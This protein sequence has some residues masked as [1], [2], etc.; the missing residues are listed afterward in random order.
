MS[1]S[2]T[3]LN[4]SQSFRLISF[5]VYIFRRPSTNYCWALIPTGQHLTAFITFP[6]AWPPAR[7]LINISQNFSDSL[8]VIKC[9]VASWISCRIY[10]HTASGGSLHCVLHSI[11][12]VRTVLIQASSHER[13][14]THPLTAPSLPSSALQG[15][16]TVTAN[17]KYKHVSFLNS[18]ERSSVL[19]PFPYLF[20]SLFSCIFQCS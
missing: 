5:S 12:Y 7:F 13:H 9:Y 2:G 10:L 11:G 3:F 8:V 17:R 1:S 4:F 18:A 15:L 19:S 20:F 6:S 16:K 14:N